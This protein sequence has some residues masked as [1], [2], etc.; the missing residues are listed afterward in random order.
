MFCLLLFV[1]F[2]SFCSRTSMLVDHA[3]TLLFL[4]YFSVL[5]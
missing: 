4:S 1:L 5:S 3:F 2:I